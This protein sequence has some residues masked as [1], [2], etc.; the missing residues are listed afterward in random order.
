MWARLA[1]RRTLINDQ[2]LSLAIL[3]TLDICNTEES[4]EQCL[5]RHQ[6]KI[7]AIISSNQARLRAIIEH[8]L[9]PK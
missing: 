7:R 4:L 3:Y 6:N 2:K 9:S 8:L 5:N 1:T